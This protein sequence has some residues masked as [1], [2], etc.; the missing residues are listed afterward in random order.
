MHWL[1][2]GPGKKKKGTYS[3][4]R[5][6]K[7]HFSTHSGPFKRTILCILAHR[8]DTL[9]HYQQLRV[10]FVYFGSKKCRYH[11]FWHPRGENLNMWFC[12][13][14]DGLSCFK[15][16]REQISVVCQSGKHLSFCFDPPKS[17]IWCVSTDMSG[18]K[19]LTSF[20]YFGDVGRGQVVLKN[21]ISIK[22]R[23]IEYS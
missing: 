16:P 19:G 9:A 2:G 1:F 22:Q 21:E 7:E 6:P 20:W 14:E 5:L 15:Q 13:Q 10:H 12:S 8:G 4:S 17:M 11:I 23:S 3:T 18:A